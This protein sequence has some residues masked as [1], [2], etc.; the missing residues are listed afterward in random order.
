MNLNPKLNGESFF[1]V[2]PDR[3]VELEQTYFVSIREQLPLEFP[4]MT[5]FKK[6]SV[7]FT[8]SNIIKADIFEVSEKKDYLEYL[9][10]YAFHGAKYDL[11]KKFDKSEKEIN[12][13]LIKSFK[14]LKQ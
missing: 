4:V 10:E 1:P 11:Y 12:Y 6:K 7:I 9:S 3:Y 2:K 8:I 13:F 5:R 14:K